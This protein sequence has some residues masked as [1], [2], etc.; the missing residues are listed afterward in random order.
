[1]QVHRARVYGTALRA[2]REEGN[3]GE[4]KEK[5]ARPPPIVM[6]IPSCGSSQISDGKKKL[7]ISRATSRSSA[8]GS[9]AR[10][11]LVALFPVT[12]KGCERKLGAERR[13]RGEGREINFVVPRMFAARAAYATW[14]TSFHELK[15]SALRCGLRYRADYCAVRARTGKREKGREQRKR[16]C[17]KRTRG[18]RRAQRG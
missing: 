11:L 14:L 15:V 9:A 7:I 17:T 6:N 3:G 2:T 4:R 8:T 12:S 1:M 5:R 10:R 13:R 18:R 16:I